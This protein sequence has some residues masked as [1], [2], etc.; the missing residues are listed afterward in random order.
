MS[1]LD[2]LQTSFLTRAPVPYICESRWTDG[3]FILPC[4]LAR[5][6]QPGG[7]EGFRGG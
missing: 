6:G 7:G 2:A 4:G 1:K 3:R 5:E